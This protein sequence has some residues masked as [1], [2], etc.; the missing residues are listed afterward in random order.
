MSVGQYVPELL[1]FYT[2]LT[3]ALISPGPNFVAVSSYAAEERLSGYGVA[4]GISL[5]TLLWASLAVTGLSATL[6]RFPTAATAVGVLGALYLM[7][8]GF[9]SLKSITLTQKVEYQKSEISIST[10]LIKKVLLGL[11]V[12]LSNPK[13]ALVW[14]ALTSIAVK[15][16]LPHI[17][18]V[19]L[20]LG[21]FAISFFWHFLSLQG[22][23]APLTFAQNLFLRQFLADC[24]CFM[25]CV[26]C[27]YRFGLN[28][29]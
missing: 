24:L 6:S 9:K 29:H 23:S 21:C 27:L 3:V 12:Q 22:Q 20:V 4:L 8:L 7:W 1:T 11:G 17:V 25:G 19:Y 13:A 14:L 28:R 5:G 16:N 2:A 18:S 26:F 15:P 10:G